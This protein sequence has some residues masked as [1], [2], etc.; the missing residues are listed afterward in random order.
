MPE[1]APGTANQLSLIQIWW[2][3][4]RPRTLPAAMAG[5]AAGVGVAVL[6][7]QVR[8]P[9]TAAALL[10]AL[11]LQIGSNLAN[12]VFDHERGADAARA[13]GPTRVTESGLLSPAQVKTGMIVVFALAA[14]LGLYL[15]ATVNWLLI[16][17]GALAILAAVAYT[18]G[19]YPLGYHGLGEIFVL[20]FFGFASVA[21]TAYINLSRLTPAAWGM[22]LPLGLLIVGILVVNNLRDIDADRLAGKNTLAV[23][24]GE[25]FAKSEYITCLVVSFLVV[26]LYCLLQIIPWWAMLTWLSLP[27]AMRNT[28]LVTT[29][30]GKPLNAALA[31]TGQL[32]LVY[33]LLFLAAMTIAR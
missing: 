16:P 3:A 28:R 5:V 24:L 20:I 14:L 10:I 25:R 22:S 30:K 17:L 6:A 19:P 23:R 13:F 11:L 9:Q 29:V 27:L 33:G 31:G 1:T 15:A 8:W 2:L 32:A 4:I 26:P 18:G 7:G 12:D 21:G